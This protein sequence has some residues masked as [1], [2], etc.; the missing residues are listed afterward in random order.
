MILRQVRHAIIALHRRVKRF[1]VIETVRQLLHRAMAPPAPPDEYDRLH[2]T[3]TAG[4]IPLWTQSIDSPNAADG[5]HY[6]TARE[7]HVR[8]LLDPLPRAATLIDLG[9]GKGRILCIAAAM[10]FQRVIGVEFVASWASIARANL[11]RL[12]LDAEVINGDVTTYTFPDGP[13]IVYLYDPF[14]PSV[15]ATVAERLRKRTDLTWVIYV[16]PRCLDA[17]SW[18][19]RLPLTGAQAELFSP[20]SVR[21]WHVNE[22]PVNVLNRPRDVEHSPGC[23]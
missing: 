4:A 11:A 2:G 15:M 23:D 20:E 3:D 8:A 17:F 21:I 16:N 9:C 5:V 10:G 19:Q 7:G 14:G 1:G 22:A 13:L 18:M 12:G 6:A